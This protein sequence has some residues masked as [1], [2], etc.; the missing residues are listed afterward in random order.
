MG[1]ERKREEGGGKKVFL[2]MYYSMAI[3]KLAALGS[4]GIDSE[5]IHFSCHSRVCHL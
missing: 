4:E 1:K 3:V 5:I 2:L